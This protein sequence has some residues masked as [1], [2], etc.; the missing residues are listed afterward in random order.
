MKVKIYLEFYV[1][2]KLMQVIEMKLLLI[3][4]K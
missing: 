3:L 4:N 2:P 1:E